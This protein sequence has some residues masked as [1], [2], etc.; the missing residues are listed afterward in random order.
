MVELIVNYF[1]FSGCFMQKIL[2]TVRQAVQQ[3]EMIAEGDKIAVGISGG[4]DSLVLLLALNMLS[5]FYPKAFEVIG[6]TVDQRF[7]GSDGDFLAIEELCRKEGIEYI[8]EKT[9][10]W[11]IVFKERREENP[12]SLCSRMRK[13]ALYDAALKHDCNKVA[14]GHHLDDAAAT[15]YM[16]LL[17]NGTLGCFSPVNELPEKG[18][19]VIRPLCLTDE[20]DIIHVAKVQ[21]IPVIQSRCTANDKTERANIEKVIKTLGENYK[22]LKEKTVGAMQRLHLCGW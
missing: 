4:K 2:K 19:T 15:F 14:L 9:D 18:I 1:K 13:G 21:K 5:K 16:N 10:I 17:N 22:N 20:R 3:Y 12:C 6:I 8:T 11:E 7:E